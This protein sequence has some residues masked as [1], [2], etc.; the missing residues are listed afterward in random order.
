MPSN[1][2]NN[3]GIRGGNSAANAV[4]FAGAFK[5]NLIVKWF[6]LIV[7]PL[8]FQSREH[9]AFEHFVGDRRGDPVDEGQA[10]LIIAT[11]E[12]EGELLLLCGSLASRLL[13]LFTR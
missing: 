11:Q 1:A 9:A 10:C 8:R 12:V 2:E 4:A 13:Q 7:C 6:W 5:V 3:A